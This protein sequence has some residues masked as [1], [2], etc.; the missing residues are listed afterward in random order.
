MPE[1]RFTLRW[2]DGAEQACV[3]PSRAIERHLV[4][5]AT[6]P[7]D[8]LVRRARD[9]LGEASDRVR[10]VH[11]QAC[12]LAARQT[13]E[14]EAAAAARSCSG[15][16]TVT[17]VR[18]DRPPP[19]AGPPVDGHHEVVIVGG[20]QAGLSVGAC[21]ARRGV[22]HLVLE[23]D[24]IGH[25]WRDERWD[26]FCLVTPNF[27]CRLPG[28]AY[29]GDDP[30]GFMVRDEIVAFVE[31][32]AVVC[33]APV[34]EGVEVGVVRR[35]G[36]AFVL[37]TSAGTVTAD[38]VVLA[39]G[40][41]HVPAIP[42]LADA[43][44]TQVTQLH[45]STYRNPTSLPDGAVLVVGSGQSGAQIA[46][47]LHRAGRA[48]HLS[49]GT[50]PR[51]ARA[52]RGRDIVAWLEDMGQYDVP[53]ERHPEGLEARKEANHYVTGRDG[54]HDIDLRAFAAEGMRLHGRLVATA[55][56]SARFAG[57]LAEN[58]DAADATYTRI[59][60]SIDKWI[61]ERRIEAPAAAEY[62]PVWEPDA[63]AAGGSALDLAARGVTSIV[64]ATGFRSDWSWVDL[65]A[66][67][68][69]GYPTHHRGVTSVDGLHVVGL[70]WLRSWG[71]GR[72]AGVARDAE[73]LADHMA[74]RRT[75]ARAA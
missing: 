66:F 68:G 70:P 62:V 27:Q 47:D 59:N 46:E 38:Q 16:V 42:R 35:D 28:H 56:G 52:H 9:G 71:S 30:D 25:A 39:V 72:F 29:A 65:P 33:D 43:F 6:Y 73:H 69:S 8:E 14:I 63:E 67:D 37:E 7:R 12:V 19:R 10:E 36:G 26:S 51:V 48:V 61:A 57:D 23:R 50:A 75:L 49:V 13:A 34:A 3:S 5:G 58:L 41:Y 17:E 22:G 4:A 18:V 32:F 74:A 11:G 31:G 20:G 53:I 45:S 54:G 44:G 2:P 40:G 24:R 64:W 21:L 1:V 55:A 15:G 60:A